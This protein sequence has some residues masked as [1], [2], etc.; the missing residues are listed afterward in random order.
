MGRRS[1]KISG[2]LLKALRRE[3]GFTQE[4]LGKRIGISR[5]TV[6]AIENEKPET[7]STIEMD[8]ISK[9]YAVCRQTASTDT[10]NRFFD[11]IMKYI[12]F[13]EQRIMNF[14][15][16]VSGSESDGTKQK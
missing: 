2:P 3:S 11:H 5:E 14:A 4:A 7:I 6:S 10:Q 12:G 15:K 1:K 9:W 8:V 16:L 13:T